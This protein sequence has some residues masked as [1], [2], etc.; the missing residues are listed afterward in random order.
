MPHSYSF[1]LSHSHFPS[2]IFVDVSLVC[3]FLHTYATLVFSPFVTLPFAPPVPQTTFP[4]CIVTT[5]NHLLAGDF[6]VTGPKTIEAD[7]VASGTRPA[8]R[9]ARDGP[10]ASPIVNHQTC[11]HNSP[12]VF[13]LSSLSSRKHWHLFNHQTSLHA[14]HP[15]FIISSISSRNHWLRVFTF[16]VF[17]PFFVFSRHAQAAVAAADLSVVRCFCLSHPILPI[18][19]TPFFLYNTPFFLYNDIVYF[20]GHITYTLDEEGLCGVRWTCGTSRG[21]MPS[22]KPSHRRERERVRATIVNCQQSAS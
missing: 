19:H 20:L 22:G 13:I 8:H 17:S 3:Q 7:Y 12:P 14:S 5:P 2:H 6:K 16:F 9:V 4:L 15:V 18:C 11:F 21:W 1:H 10:T